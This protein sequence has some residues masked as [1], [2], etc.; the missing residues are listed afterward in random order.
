MDGK[1]K[2][3]P[4]LRVHWLTKIFDIFLRVTMPERRLK[5]MLIQLACIREDEKIL[6]FGCGTGT[7]ALMIKQT[8]TNANVYGVDVDSKILEIAEKKI[9]RSSH[10]IPLVKYDGI[11]L[12]YEDKSFNKVLSSLVF[13]HLYPDQ[14]VNALIDIYRVL[15]SDGELNIIDFGK[16]RN[17]FMRIL[18]FPMQVLDG[19]PNTQDNIKGRI[20]QLM[21]NAGFKE[22]SEV[23]R[24]TTVYGTLSFYK[25]KKV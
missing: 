21:Q 8:V 7:L 17:I 20:P 25:G 15:K 18:F 1:N 11:T 4:A 5:E 12:P 9:K 22:V 23:I 2:F 6:D 16:A 24:V 14:K 13:H 3:I 10:E 19:I